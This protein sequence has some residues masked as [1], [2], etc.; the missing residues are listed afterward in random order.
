[1][2]MLRLV[3][4]LAVGAVGTA[5]AQLAVNQPT[6][7]LLLLPLVWSTAADSAAAIGITDAAR[8]RLGQMARY[9]VLLVPKAKICE[10]LKASG[11]PCDGLMEPRQADQ[12]ARFLSVPSYTQGTLGHSTASYAARIHVVSGGSGFSSTFS[13]TGGANGTPNAISEAIAQRLFT[14]IKAAENARNC[15]EQR[16]RNNVQKALEE[17]R[18][19]LLIDPTLTAAHLCLINVYE[20]QR[21]GPDSTI[22]QARAALAGD[23]L[24]GE[25]WNRLANGYLAKGD[26]AGWLGA[27]AGLV[28]SDIHNIN[29]GVGVAT[30][31]IQHKQYVKAVALLNDVAA[32]NPGNSQITDLIKR[33]CIEGEQWRCVIDI[34]RADSASWGDSVSLRIAIGAA[35]SLPDT[36]ANLFFT[37]QAADHFPRSVP[38][39]KT[40]AS[41]FDMAGQKDSALA[42]YLRALQ[43]DPTDVNL[44]LQ[45]AKTLVD[46]A[47]F[48][49][50][51]FKH[52]QVAKDSTCI[53]GMP[54]AFATR[55]DSAR[56]YLR[57]GAASS[58]SGQRL[59][60][61]VIMLSAGSKLAQA[62]AHDRAYPWLDTLI[63]LVAPRAPADTVGPRQQIRVQASFW[64]G[65]SSVL[66]LG[67]DYGIMIKSK[68]C[69]K[70]REVSDRI[71]RSK[72]ALFLG[73]R[74][75]PQV[76]TQMLGYLSQYEANIPKAK[77]A[78]HC[79]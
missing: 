2:R 48:D 60:A 78:F 3:A 62:S 66:S 40:R 51:A 31:F 30:L 35:Q 70:L 59:T 28:H 56:P 65:L 24:S 16:G 17:A 75:A 10:A 15:N 73:G 43:V 21:L 79:S 38:F 1:V 76:A 36:A 54:A 41:A 52:C 13:V 64:Y 20:I 69:G 4:V 46:R 39:L 7:K 42:Y 58:D 47:V 74:I 72:Q 19:A 29:T 57:P 34:F 25:A 61:A 26:T 9:K 55:V 68:N 23:S 44:S 63:T 49:T 53:K 45:I 22:A 71:Q 11:F 27:L 50:A 8:E 6:E 37:K 33:T 32:A 12:L 67:P 5:P 18:K 77:Q 14:I